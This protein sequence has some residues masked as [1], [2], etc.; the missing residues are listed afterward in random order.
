[1]HKPSSSHGRARSV[2]LPLILLLVTW[3]WCAA[4]GQGAPTPRDRQESVAEI[5][6]GQRLRV[7]TVL[8]QQR[9]G[10]FVG[11]EPPDLQ[12]TA[13]T[14]LTTI[15]LADVE[16]LW[17]RGR[18]TKTGAVIGTLAGTVIGA[19]WGLFIGEVICGGPDCQANTA[20]AVLV[21]GLVGGGGGA[22]LGALIGLAVPKWHQR[23]P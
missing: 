12:I 19:A 21:F 9:E 14:A 1:M 18:G 15:P 20:H 16:R 17:V 22:A 11:Y 4:S 7:S 23:F 8:G 2:T 3:P 10:V 6:M 13:G 5:Q